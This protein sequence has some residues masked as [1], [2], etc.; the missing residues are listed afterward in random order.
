MDR[1]GHEIGNNA[2]HSAAA[3]AINLYATMGQGFLAPSIQVFAHLLAAAADAD[4]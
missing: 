2:R 4:G 1:H 3:V